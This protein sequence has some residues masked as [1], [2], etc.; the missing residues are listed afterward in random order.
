MQLC[1]DGCHQDGEE[2]KVYDVDSNADTAERPELDQAPNEIDAQ[3]QGNSGKEDEKIKAGI[4]YDRQDYHQ[5]EKRI[6]KA[7]PESVGLTE[8][9]SVRCVSDNL[10]RT[11]SHVADPRNPPDIW[12]NPSPVNLKE[13]E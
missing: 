2:Q 12:M 9:S 5:Q 8:E 10:T 7:S 1:S 4:V 3:K 11:G 13:I 6:E